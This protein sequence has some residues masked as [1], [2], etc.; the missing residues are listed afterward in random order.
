[1][2]MNAIYFYQVRCM[3]VHV[4]HATDLVEING[5]TRVLLVYTCHQGVYLR[6]H[7]LPLRLPVKGSTSSFTVKVLSAVTNN[8]C[9][10]SFACLSSLNSC[11]SHCQY[12]RY[13]I[14]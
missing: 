6:G 9:L 12:D 10:D 5:I 1:M 7:V 11:L 4:M 2:D 8:K 14:L 3:H 13:H